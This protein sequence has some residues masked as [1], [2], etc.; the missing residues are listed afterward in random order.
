[1][2]LRRIRAHVEAENWFAVFL[3][4]AIVVLGVFI[5]IQLGNWNAE[6]QAR[7][8]DA[9]FLGRIAD[10]IESDAARLERAVRNWAVEIE[11]SPRIERFLAGEPVAGKTPWQSLSKL[12]FSAGWSPFAHDTTT[13]DELVASGR[14]SRVGDLA[15]RD[16][17]IGYY[18]TLRESVP[19]YAY[20][21]PVR[22]LIRSKIGVQTHT[23]LWTACFSETL[24][25]ETRDGQVPCPPPEAGPPAERMVAALRADPAI[26]D[27]YRFTHS[28]RLIAY[29]TAQVDA[30]RAAE[31]AHRIR[32]FEP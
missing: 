7:A 22:E 27:Q 8:A 25:R 23:Y 9:V 28:M 13:Y 4:F 24:Y 14:F 30:G 29:T 32:S 3:D 1:M 26:L 20:D 5:G 6:Q 17:I 18:N 15:L 31:L 2:I 19:F 12:Y 16:E 10:D 11:E 21:P